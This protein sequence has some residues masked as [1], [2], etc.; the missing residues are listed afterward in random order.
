[1]SDTYALLYSVAYS[2][3]GC[4][5]FAVTIEVLL[6]F[7]WRY[8]TGVFQ[9]FAIR[10]ILALWG[11]SAPWFGM[12]LVLYFRVPRSIVWSVLGLYLLAIVS[13]VAFGRLKPIVVGRSES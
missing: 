4:L 5:F 10:R 1:M 6:Y 12:M 3:A 13:A 11:M 9:T 8:R 2:L 7:S